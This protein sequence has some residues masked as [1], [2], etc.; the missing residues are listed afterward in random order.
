[1][2]YPS[3]RDPLKEWQRAAGAAGQPYTL[4]VDAGGA[5]VG[6]FA[7]AMDAPTLARRVEERLGVPAPPAAALLPALSDGEPA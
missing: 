6:R 7:G 2:S 4:L 5:V 1:M 3:V